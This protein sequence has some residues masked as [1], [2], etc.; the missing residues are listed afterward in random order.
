MEW[1]PSLRQSEAQ[2]PDIRARQAGARAAKKHNILN[3]I[4]LANFQ[5]STK[6]EVLSLP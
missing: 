5:S 6:I 3:R 1:C 2:I 4:N